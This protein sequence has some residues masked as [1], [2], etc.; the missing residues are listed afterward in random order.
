MSLAQEVLLALLALT[1]G[2]FKRR[3]LRGYYFVTS[4]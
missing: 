4:Q 2:S 3:A 1:A